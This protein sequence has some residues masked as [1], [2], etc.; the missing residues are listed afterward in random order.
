[1][2]REGWEINFFNPPISPYFG[3]RELKIYMP[4]DLDE[5]HLRSEFRDPEPKNVAWGT[6]VEIKNFNCSGCRFCRKEF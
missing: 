5:L 4:L 2:L 6:I 3:F 1:M